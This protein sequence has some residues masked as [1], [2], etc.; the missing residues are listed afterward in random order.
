MIDRRDMLKVSSVAAATAIMEGANIMANGAPL[1]TDYSGVREYIG[2]RYV[3][4]FANPLAWSDQR[5]Y[6]PLTIVTYQGNSYTSMQYVPTGIDIENTAFWALT[7]NYNAQVEAY[8]NE[9]QAFDGRITTAQETADSALEVANQASSYINNPVTLI[10]GDSW[11][12]AAAA[13]SWTKYYA[14]RGIVKNYAKSGAGYFHSTGTIVS[15]QVEQA[16]SDDSFNHDDVIKIIVICGANDFSEPLNSVA[17]GAK[18]AFEKIRSEWAKIPTHICWNICYTQS[19]TTDLLQKLAAVA[20]WA[21]INDCS[22]DSKFLYLLMNSTNTDVFQSDNV[23]PNEFG[24]QIISSYM[25]NPFSQITIGGRYLS[26]G[27][28]CIK[29]TPKLQNNVTNVVVTRAIMNI[30]DGLLK[31]SINVT[32]DL[33][34]NKQSSNVTFDLNDG[35]KTYISESS[36]TITPTIYGHTNNFE[37]KGLLTILNNDVYIRLEPSANNNA[38]TIDTSFQFAIPLA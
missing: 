27:K 38:T 16:I 29:S 37:V 26:G 4:V 3:P 24:S 10:F 22:F 23:H 17:N 2:A 36:G 13:I 18:T 34:N 35:L 14:P 9:V 12:D 11:S 1:A 15:Q 30:D 32:M 6:E 28:L 19:F 33:V 31:M 25:T 20:N 21:N 7:G 8:R 5:E